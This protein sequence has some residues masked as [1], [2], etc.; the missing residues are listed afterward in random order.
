MERNSDFTAAVFSG[1]IDLASEKLGGKVLLAN[2]EFF[3]EKENLIKPGRGVWIA[4]KYTDRG[5]WM[6]GWETRRKRVPGYDWCILKLGTAGVIEGVDIDTNNFLGNHP[7]YASIDALYLEE[8]MADDKLPEAKWTEILPKSPLKQGS[9]NIFAVSDSNRWTHIRLNIY[10][11]GGVARLKV[12][13]T[14]SKHWAAIK[15]DEQI[16]LAAVE[17]GGSVVACNDMFFG[18]KNNMI[19]P[20][21]GVNMGDGWE[22]R[23]RR[24]QGHDWSIVELAQP[25]ILKKIEVDTK[26]YKGN[27]PDSCWIDAC[28][29]PG[30]EMNNLTAASFE[31]TKVVAQTKLQADHRHFFEKEI[32]AQGPWTHLRLNIVPDGGISRFRVWC[33]LPA[34]ATRDAKQEKSDGRKEYQRT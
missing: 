33:T 7:P 12:Y 23:R 15:P 1:F 29:A 11:D 30:A 6:D 24:D 10:P 27:F 3:A 17:N 13:G 4:D 31:W 21:S 34:T 19:M 14:V 28:Y 8:D 25:G 22:T 2:D 32:L 5:K 26:H 16:D 9:Q 20:G 18:N